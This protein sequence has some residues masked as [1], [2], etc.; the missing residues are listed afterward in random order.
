M[1]MIGGEEFCTL[2]CH[3]VASSSF[4]LLASSRRTILAVNSAS[5]EAWDK[6]E[7]PVTHTVHLKKIRIKTQN[8]VQKH[9]YLH[10]PALLTPSVKNIP[11]VPGSS[12]GLQPVWPVLLWP[13]QPHASLSPA[14][15]PP[16][17]PSFSP[18]PAPRPGES[19][20]Q[21]L[22]KGRHTNMYP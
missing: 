2:C 13:P 6:I 4:F 15:R 22:W 5:S 9:K 8:C 19:V 21:A 20:P 14:S 11:V 10:K 1:C 17:S 16:P 3:S 18:A 7:T 12:A